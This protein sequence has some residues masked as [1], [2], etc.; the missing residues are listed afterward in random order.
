M[1]VPELLPSSWSAVS[2]VWVRAS[3][4]ICL[5]RLVNSI[6]ENTQSQ[7]E[8][9][10]IMELFF[11]AVIEQIIAFKLLSFVSETLCASASFPLF[12]RRAPEPLLSPCSPRGDVLLRWLLT[13]ESSSC[14]S[15]VLSCWGYDSGISVITDLLESS[16]GTAPRGTWIMGEAG[17]TQ[18]G[19]SIRLHKF[20]NSAI[21]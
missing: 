1:Q 9:K 10:R 20:V 16:P 19:A 4:I 3:T 15:V 5:L 6:P 13:D 12:T 18:R 21:Y 17:G 2:S 14:F 8:V 11:N 7:R